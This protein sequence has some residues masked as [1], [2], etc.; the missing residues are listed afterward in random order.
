MTRN[1]EAYFGM[2]LKVKNFGIKKTAELLFI[3]ATTGYFTL[4]DDKI[5]QLITADT[6][7]RVDL[8]GFAIVKSKKREIVERFAL[9]VSNAAATYAMVNDDIVLQ[10]KTDF[11]SS[12]WYSASEEELIAQAWL[13]HNLANPIAASLA[14]FGATAAEVDLLKTSIDEFTNVIADPT[15][16]IDQRKENNQLIDKTIEEIRVFLDTKLDVIMRSFE[17]NKPSLFELYRSARAIDINGSVQQ[18]T[19][20]VDTEANSITTIYKS[21]VYD[22]NTFYTIQNKGTAAVSFGL[23]DTA[24]GEAPVWVALNPGETRSRLA[25]NLAPT[26]N[27]L[28]G[29]NENPGKVS[30]RLWVE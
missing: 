16:A 17:A 23:A 27:Y 4:L 8:T 18:P 12:K 24:A 14:D 3:P 29:K 1:Q 13:V 26:G 30:V 21:E 19:M 9:K 10:K 25:S 15:L 7:S 11:P 28:V 2:T 20:V 22:E 5:Q 6:G